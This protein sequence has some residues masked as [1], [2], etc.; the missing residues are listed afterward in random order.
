MRFV[1][2]K[3]EILYEDNH[4]LVVNKPSGWATMGLPAG[5]ETLLTR[6]KDYIA[7]KYQKPGNV[8]LGVVSRLDTPVT[9]VVVFARTSK[10]ADRLNEQFRSH[11]VEKRYLAVVEG[12][13][14]PEG[15]LR[16][17]IKEDE[18]HKKCHIT[19]TAQTAKGAKGAKDERNAQTGPAKEAILHFR[20]L[21]RLELNR[22]LVAVRLETGRKHQIRLQL[23]HAGYPILGDWKYGSRNF[24]TDSARKPSRRKSEAKIALHARCLTVQHPTRDEKMTFIAPIPA[25]WGQF[26]LAQSDFTE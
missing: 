11:I 22:S 20:R 15:T 13:I 9:G 2:K 16:D 19:K 17:W 23:S 3:L 5:E 14:P 12:I 4:L 1:T 7:E 18:H 25:F 21:R 6:A 10:A 26:G 8:Y 24:V